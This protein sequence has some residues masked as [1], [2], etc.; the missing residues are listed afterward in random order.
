MKVVPGVPGDRI[1]TP[2]RLD[3]AFETLCAAPAADVAA[4][5]GIRPE[6]ARILAAGAAILEAILARYGLQRATAS[7]EGIREGTVLALAR[8]GAAW[9][10]RLEPLAH[11]WGANGA[12]DRIR[13]R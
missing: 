13:G 5:F 11:G 3:A 9:R 1:L 7:E 8:A 4:R 6:R 12:A 2:A 10:D